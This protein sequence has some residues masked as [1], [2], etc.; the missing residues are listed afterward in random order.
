MVCH[1]LCNQF[2]ATSR[3][4]VFYFQLD[5]SI[6]PGILYSVGRMPF[7]SHIVH[8]QFKFTSINIALRII[9]GISLNRIRKNVTNYFSDGYFHIKQLYY[10]QHYFHVQIIHTFS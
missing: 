2:I 4:V 10:Y 1:Y 8:M 5:N 3:S 9:D 7:S 6:L